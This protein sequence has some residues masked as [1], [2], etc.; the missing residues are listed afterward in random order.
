MLTQ[1]KR[2]KAGQEV[3]LVDIPADAGEG[4]GCWEVL[5]NGTSPAEFTRYLK[6]SSLKYYGNAIRSFLKLIPEETHQK[7]LHEEF[8]KTREKLE[9]KY[10]PGSPDGKVQRVFM[11][12]LLVAHA[13]ELAVG[14]GILPFSPEACIDAA[15]KCFESWL[16]QRGTSGSREIDEG[17]RQIRLFLEEHQDSRFTM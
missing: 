9:E 13:G 7:F 11:R 5:P 15:M 8:E 2:I 6:E 4:K 16:I 3:R 17:I 14:M 1:G 12:F 10:L